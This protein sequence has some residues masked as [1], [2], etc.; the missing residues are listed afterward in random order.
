L[1]AVGSHPGRLRR[2]RRLLAGLNLR[3]PNPQIPVQIGDLALGLL[4]DPGETIESPD[5]ALQ[6]VPD[7]DGVDLVH[8]VGGPGAQPEFDQ[9]RGKLGLFDQRGT[10][11]GRD[12]VAAGACLV[13]FGEDR[14]PRVMHLAGVVEA[15]SEIPPQRVLEEIDQLLA[16]IGAEAFREKVGLTDQR[17]RSLDLSRF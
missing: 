12:E 11:G 1:S 8:R 5:R 7:G 17:C 16:Q 3:E 10:R 14:Q 15:V 13:Q 9:R 6:Q 2:L 4:A